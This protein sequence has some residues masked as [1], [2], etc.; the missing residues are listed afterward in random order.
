MIRDNYQ[1]LQKY[2]LVKDVTYPFGFNSI[3]AHLWTTAKKCFSPVKVQSP[4][5]EYLDVLSEYINDIS[6]SSSVKSFPLYNYKLILENITKYYKGEKH[7]APF[8]DWWLSF[9]VWRRELGL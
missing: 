3:Q 5:V 2:P 9:E 1:A 6:L 8:L 4:Q 7:L